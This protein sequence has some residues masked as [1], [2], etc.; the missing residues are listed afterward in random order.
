MV[1]G[2]YDRH[3]SLGRPYPPSLFKTLKGEYFLSKKDAIMW[4]QMH[5]E[6]AIDQYKE[7]T[8]NSVSHTGLILF[9]CGF[10]GCSPD[11]IITCPLS[12]Q[13]GVL[14]VK[15][16]WKHRNH[17]IEEMIQEEL[18]G[19]DATNGFFLTHDGKL[20]ENHHY[21]HQVQGEI[22]AANVNWAHFVIWTLKELKVIHVEKSSSWS[23]DN[24]PKLEAF[25]LKE[26]LPRCYC[27]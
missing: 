2:A 21:F 10:L 26:L 22:A 23:E 12:N 11:G 6:K 16:P 24:L 9:P 14:E 4:G 27:A 25:Y 5:K 1:L 7:H 15:C 3:I 8:G 20:N 13:H 19:K 17:S 18:K